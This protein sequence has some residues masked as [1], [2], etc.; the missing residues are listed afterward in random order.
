MEILK[1]SYQTLDTQYKEALKKMQNMSA[2]AS[3]DDLEAF[4]AVL[5]KQCVRRSFTK[6]GS[7]N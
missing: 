5:M 2:A 7:K 1:N 3:T 4:N 6:I